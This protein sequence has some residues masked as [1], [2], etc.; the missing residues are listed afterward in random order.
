MKHLIATAA[1]TATLC[2]CGPMHV[3]TP[4]ETRC[5]GSFVE[6]CDADGRWSPAEDCAGVAGPQLFSTVRMAWVAKG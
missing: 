3:C 1:F 5:A 6:V 2:A 4:T